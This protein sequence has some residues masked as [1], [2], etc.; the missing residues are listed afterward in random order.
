MHLLIVRLV[1][2]KDIETKTNEGFDNSILFEIEAIR[3]SLVLQFCIVT[4]RICLFK[5]FKIAK[6]SEFI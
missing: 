2:S 3:A 4:K 6:R 5:E 1:M